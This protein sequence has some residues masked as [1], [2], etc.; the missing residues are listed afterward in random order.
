MENE[1]NR[2]QTGGVGGGRSEGVRREDRYAGKRS[3]GVLEEKDGACEHDG[4]YNERLDCGAT[5]WGLFGCNAGTDV[6][7]FGARK[8]LIVQYVQ[9]GVP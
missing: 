8:V 2:Q 7:R 4:I 9:S 5:S 3:G 6:S 1:N